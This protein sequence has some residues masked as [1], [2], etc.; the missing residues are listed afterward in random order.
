MDEREQARRD[1]E[2]VERF[3]ADPVILKALAD[4]ELDVVREWKA[5]EQWDDQNACWYAIKAMEQFRAKLR[6][7]VGRGQQA[8]LEI[9]RAR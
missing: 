2:T 4:M 8:A 7:T 1:G 3:L 6:A 5:A 9:E